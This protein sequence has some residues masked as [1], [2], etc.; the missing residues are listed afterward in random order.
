M[1]T[2][3]EELF[4]LKYIEKARRTSDRYKCND[5]TRKGLE[6]IVK[7]GIPHGFTSCDSSWG[8]GLP[9]TRRECMTCHKW[10]GPWLDANIV[11]GGH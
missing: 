3:Q 1:G 8:P 2:P 10:D 9:T 6:H 4:S 11:G 7:V 5:C